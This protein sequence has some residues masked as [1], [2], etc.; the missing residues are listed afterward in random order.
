[1][2]KSRVYF[3][4]TKGVE[5]TEHPEAVK[6]YQAVVQHAWAEYLAV[7]HRAWVEYQAV[8]NH[9]R[10]VLKTELLAE[11]TGGHDDTI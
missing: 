2:S 11:L 7:E 3:F 8:V 1:M 9:A 5:L 10:A 6:K 4:D